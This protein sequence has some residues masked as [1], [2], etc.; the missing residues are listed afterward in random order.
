MR[1]Y[2][3]ETYSGYFDVENESEL[4]DKGL[5]EQV[6]MSNSRTVVLNGTDKDAQY[7]IY[8]NAIDN[9]SDNE[10]RFYLWQLCKWYENEIEKELVEP[11]TKAEYAQQVV[12]KEVK[13]A[14]EHMDWLLVEDLF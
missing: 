2:Y 6:E 9:M 13:K 10:K 8:D 7:E 14:L 5:I 1:V 4:V 11:K 3:E 12:F